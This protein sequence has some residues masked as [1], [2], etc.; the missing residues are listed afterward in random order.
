MNRIDRIDRFERELP[1]A[2]QDGSASCLLLGRASRALGVHRGDQ[3]VE[4]CTQR[5]QVAD[6]RGLVYLAADLPDLGH[7]PFR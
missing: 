6:A 3:G 5:L 7:R 1:A 4:P 2:L